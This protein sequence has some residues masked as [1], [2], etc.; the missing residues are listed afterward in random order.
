MIT[1]ARV[2]IRMMNSDESRNDSHTRKANV[3]DGYVVCRKKRKREE[4]WRAEE[5]DLNNF[6]LFT[7]KL[8]RQVT[9]NS[10]GWVTR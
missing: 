6:P 5:R 4:S 10:N 9:K 3:L 8:L 1:E 2:M 7:G